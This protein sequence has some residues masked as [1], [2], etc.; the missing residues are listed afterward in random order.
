ML[1]GST[2][3][4]CCCLKFSIPFHIVHTLNIILNSFIFLHKCIHFNKR[5]YIHQMELNKSSELYY[6]IVCNYVCM[7]SCARLFCN[8]SPF[9]SGNCR[10]LYINFSTSTSNKSTSWISLTL[11]LIGWR[12]FASANQR[13]N[14]L[15]LTSLIILTCQL[16][17]NIFGVV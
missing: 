12:R 9:L 7:V 8:R 2:S 5:N 14:R 6:C 17:H 1:S 16:L 11:Y 3:D 15:T 4:V 10:V 13:V